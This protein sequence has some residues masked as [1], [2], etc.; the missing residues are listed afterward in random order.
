MAGS[1]YRNIAIQRPNE[2]TSRRYYP[3]YGEIAFDNEVLRTNCRVDASN[4][5]LHWQCNAGRLRSENWV[6]RR[7]VLV[8]TSRD[9]GCSGLLHVWACLAVSMKV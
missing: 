1:L 9:G 8:Y 2:I 6:R 5:S 4:I 7:G 3:L